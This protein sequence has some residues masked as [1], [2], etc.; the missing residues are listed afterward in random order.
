M[1]IPARRALHA[2]RRTSRYVTTH[3]EI[4]GFDN[5]PIPVPYHSCLPRCGP[6]Y[7][8]LPVYSQSNS[9]RHF[10]VSGLSAQLYF[11]H[12]TGDTLYERAL[13]LLL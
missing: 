2:P 12:S 4:K 8:L 5:K 7:P 10:R 1:V 6:L 13:F 9:D 3:R 11:F